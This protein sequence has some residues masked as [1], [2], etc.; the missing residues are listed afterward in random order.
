LPQS[1]TLSNKKVPSDNCLRFATKN[2]QNST[3]RR[4]GRRR[5]K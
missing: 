5:N 1:L 4:K 2:R 3:R